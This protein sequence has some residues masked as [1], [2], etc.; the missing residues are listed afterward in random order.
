MTYRK[1]LNEL[2]APVLGEDGTYHDVKVRPKFRDLETGAEAWHEGQPWSLYWWAEGNGCCDCNREDVFGHDS[3]HGL[4]GF[5]LGYK[6]YIVVDLEGI[7][8]PEAK[9]LAI[10]WMN[11]GYNRGSDARLTDKVS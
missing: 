2:M 11:E 9:A 6:R 5:C 10:E 4:C 8:D 3:N 7:D 1:R